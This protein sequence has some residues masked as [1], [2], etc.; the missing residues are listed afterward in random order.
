MP[1][2]AGTFWLKT[3]VVEKDPL[4]AQ[5]LINEAAAL[6]GQHRQDVVNYATKLINPG[7]SRSPTPAARY[8]LSRVD[9]LLFISRDGWGFSVSSKVVSVKRREVVCSAAVTEYHQK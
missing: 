6:V 4:N 8:G 7:A 2:G 1:I 3:T 5:Q 9:S